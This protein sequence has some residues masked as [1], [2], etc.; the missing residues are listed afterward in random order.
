MS[1]L[2]DDKEV[3]EKG[4]K[5]KL[6]DNEDTGLVVEA[7]L[8][9]QIPQKLAEKLADLDLGEKIE[10]VWTQAV[11]DRVDWLTRQDAYLEEIDEFVDSI[12]QPANDWSSTIHL[13]TTLTVIKTF[14]AR[15][16]SALMGVEPPFTVRARTSANTDRATLVQDLM[17]YTLKDWANNYEGI[18]D[19]VDRWIWDWCAV[20]VGYLKARW[21]ERYTRFVDVE[22]LQ[23][24]VMNL[25]TNPETGR[26]EQTPGTELVEREVT[27]TIQ[28]FAGPCL[29]H[30][31][32]E[33]LVIVGGQGDPQKADYIFQQSQM[34]ASD[35][36]ML[37]DRGIFREDAVR[38]VIRKGED[39]VE[40][41]VTG[42]LK[43][44][45]KENAGMADV[46]RTYDI[47]R[48]TVL[49]CYLKV[50][51]DGSGIESDIIVWMNPETKEIFRANYLYRVMPTGLRPFFPIHFHLR[52]GS[53]YPVGLAELLHSLSREIDAMH[54]I[55]MDIG[56]LTSM[57]FGFYRPS[58][59]TNEE[60]L[61][62][63][64]GTL[65][66]LDNPGQDVFFPNLG[67][68]V[69]FGFQEQQA[70]QSQIERLTSISDI[71]LGIIAG[72]G[73][74]RTATGTRAL[75][76][77][78]N[79]NLD[80]FLQRMNRGWKR[81]L[82]YMF[83]ML[84][85]KLPPGFDFRI[86]GDDG[87]QYWRR[88]ESREE[89]AGMYDFE[90]EPNSA[91]SNKQIQLETANQIYQ[92]TQNPIDLQLGL[93]SPLQ[94]YEAVKNLLQTMGVTDFGRFIKKPQG[95]VRVFTPQEIA[96]RL[97]SGIDVP[98]DPTQD[99]QGFINYVQLIMSE[100]ELLG[101]FDQNAVAVLVAKMQEAQGMLSALNAAQQQQAQIQQQQLNQQAG[102]QSLIAPGQDAGVAT[103]VQGSGQGGQGS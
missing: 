55:T 99:L 87:N 17:Q 68:R 62:I 6:E 67:N 66:P 102:T 54:N 31:Q 97:L 58:T 42:M 61:P 34:T 103:P 19:P 64:P 30:I 2:S 27:K 16:Y 65:V 24:P 21:D 9:E 36:W 101:Q 90:L 91:N 28:T 84:Q 75:I 81:A 57:P 23:M 69:A 59:S 88:V 45:R 78:A 72:Q 74:T 79:A 29:E 86:T 63:E 56:I 13:P 93:I 18:S 4:R 95:I 92:M 83:H 85:Q 53:E 32:I 39:S 89:L 77:E 20:G 80:I 46:N 38:E 22:E 10:K 41:N 37:V 60:K 7:P 12:Y 40:N 70:L 43:Q 26:L 82:K 100:D 11:N 71:S 35:L 52:N 73:A 47:D 3:L 14:H 25:A 96:D 44:Q 8:R 50:D 33:D 15:M 51:V 48:Y 1:I 76:G 5:N 98:L 49:E 94:R